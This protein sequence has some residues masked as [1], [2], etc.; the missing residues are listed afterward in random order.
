MLAL[1]DWEKEGESVEFGGKWLSAKQLGVNFRSLKGVVDGVVGLLKSGKE[2][3]REERLRR[4][5]ALLGEV[6]A[7]RGGQGTFRVE[8]FPDEKREAEWVAAKMKECRAGR[9]E[10][11]VLV[12]ARSYYSGHIEPVLQDRRDIDVAFTPLDRQA[13]V[14]DMIAL[15]RSVEDPGDAVACLALLRSPL[16]GLSSGEIVELYGWLRGVKDGEGARRL[17]T[18]L[19]AVLRAGVEVKLPGGIGESGGA[20]LREWVSTV[21]RGRAEMGRLSVRGRLERAWLRMGGGVL[22]C[23][24]EDLKNVEEV[25]DLVEQV[26]VGG[27]YCDWGELASAMRRRGGASRYPGAK[28]RV[29]TI[30]AAKGL[31]FERVVVPFLNRAERQPRKDL[32][33]FG[34]RTSEDGRKVREVICDDGVEIKGL[35]D[36]K[37]EYARLW[38]AER[39]RYREESR[40]L[41]YV[42]ATRAKDECYLTYSGGEGQF[43]PGSMMAAVR[44]VKAGTREAGDSS[45]CGGVCKA[46]TSEV[47]HCGGESDGDGGAAAGGRDRRRVGDFRAVREHIEGVRGLYRARTVRAAAGSG[48]QAAVGEV[49]HEELVSILE[50]WPVGGADARVEDERWRRECG[51][52][53]ERK[54]WSAANGGADEG[55]EEVAGHLR[56]A[57]G[58]RVVGRLKELVAE[59]GE[60]DWLVEFEKEFQGDGDLCGEGSE[61]RGKRLDV[62]IR[63]RMRNECMIIDFKTGRREGDAK[64]SGPE[65]EHARQVKCY[66][67]LVRKAWKACSVAT[68]LYVF[69]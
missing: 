19:E 12:R 50:E 51:R 43:K 48:R 32:V 49:V 38:C 55:V 18:P 67:K 10:L 66:E 54:G 27:A 30:H 8:K 52:N 24:E 63:S 5:V 15:G 41:L 3:A 14:R 16:V 1:L 42:A 59:E 64:A 21:W 69:G 9:K 44:D 17:G 37:G 39:E 31:E 34:E 62:V 7:D 60:G 4:G 13:C 68:A 36:E 53:L 23:R 45:G 40:R 28:V 65:R 26:S 2:V 47:E 6:K 22:Y 33:M 57:Y 58:D 56:R 46:A 25:L 11:V 61:G 29:M 35:D 20:A